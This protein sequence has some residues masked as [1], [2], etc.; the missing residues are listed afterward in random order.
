MT[1]LGPDVRR[2]RATQNVG[3]FIVWLFED[4]TLKFFKEK[5]C[6]TFQRETCWIIWKKNQWTFWWNKNDEFFEEKNDKLVEEMNDEFFFRKKV[7]NFL[8][9]ENKLRCYQKKLMKFW[10]DKSR[11]FFFPTL[12]IDAC[13]CLRVSSCRRNCIQ[14]KKVIRKLRVFFLPFFVV[15]RFTLLCGEVYEINRNV[16]IS[17]RNDW[18][19]IV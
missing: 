9:K 18:M 10:N 6:W 3:F 8:K 12:S 15:V 11:F 17:L 13:S 7:A 1:L 16:N 14:S 4:E 2:S 19:D 5:K